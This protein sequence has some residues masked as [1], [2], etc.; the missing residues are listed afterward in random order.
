MDIVFS[1]N[2]SL[3][4]KSKVFEQKKKQ[5]PKKKQTN[6]SSSAQHGFEDQKVSIL[7]A[8]NLL[9]EVQDIIIED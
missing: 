6:N 4:N 3:N 8:S 2:S 9:S 7:A 5:D 1:K